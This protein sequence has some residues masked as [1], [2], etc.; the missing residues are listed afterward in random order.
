MIE[1][2]FQAVRRVSC[3]HLNLVVQVIL[4]FEFFV[5]CKVDQIAQILSHK[6]E[7]F[8]CDCNLFDPLCSFGISSLSIRRLRLEDFTERKQC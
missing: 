3:Q 5:I 2:L 8:G 4:L 7:L 1:V 6:V